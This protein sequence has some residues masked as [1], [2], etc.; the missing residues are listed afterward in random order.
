MLNL[1]HFPAIKG[2]VRHLS[3]N[4]GAGGA[5]GFQRMHPVGTGVEKCQSLCDE[6]PFGKGKNHCSCIMVRGNGQCYLLDGLT[7]GGCNIKQCP[8]QGPTKDVYVRIKPGMCNA[9]N[10]SISYVA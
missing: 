8:D 10:I 3:R 7:D 6:L 4:C 9:N 5:G 1:F 2:Y